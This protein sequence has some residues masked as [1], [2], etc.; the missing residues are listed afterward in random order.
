MTKIMTTSGK[1]INPRQAKLKKNRDQRAIVFLW[2]SLVAMS[3]LAGLGW[4]LTRP[5]WVIR[6][7]SQI[8]ISNNEILSEEAVRQLIS[9]SYPQSIF[10]LPISKLTTELETKPPIQQVKIT[11]QLFPPTVNLKISERIPVAIVLNSQSIQDAIGFIDQEG[12]FLPE[13]FYSSVQTDFILPQLTV[14]G[15]QAE[16]SPD[17]PQL[18]QIINQSNLEIKQ[19]DHRDN[20]NL[21]LTTKLGKIYLGANR[22]ILAEQLQVLEKMVDLP[23]RIK[24]QD[25][26]YIDLTDPTNPLIQVFEKKVN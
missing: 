5:N 25:I 21:I 9:L 15:F 24:I 20:N 3:I 12:T 23:S 13:E 10:K 19:I 4:I 2:R 17:W 11:R 6:E 7:N 18:Y 1:K 14:I 26:D 22:N 8:E 16:N